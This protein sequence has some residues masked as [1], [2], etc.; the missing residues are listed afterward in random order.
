MRIAYLT[1][2]EVNS[3]LAQCWANTYD[4]EVIPLS[5]NDPRPGEEFDAAIY[6]LDYLTPPVR[7]QML[8]YLFSGPLPI[9]A[10][11]HSYNLPQRQVKDL[12][13]HGVLVR[14]RLKR[15]IFASLRHFVDHVRAEKRQSRLVTVAASYV[16]QQ[17]SP[18]SR[19]RYAAG[20]SRKHSF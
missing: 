19:H 10:A 18:S 5:P 17:L 1:T 7:Q 3:D 9:P 16:D 8:N 4:C 6:D 12:C 11:V 13:A 2:D 15:G 20:A 14:R